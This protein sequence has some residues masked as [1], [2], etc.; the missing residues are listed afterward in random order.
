LTLDEL[1]GSLDKP[2]GLDSADVVTVLSCGQ[3]EFVIKEPLWGT[4]EEC[5]RWVNIDWSAFDQRLVAFLWI[6]F[7]C[8]PEES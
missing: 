6:L 2:L 3:H 5:G 7:G 8:I 4:V 1:R